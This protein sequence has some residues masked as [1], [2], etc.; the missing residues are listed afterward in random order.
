M[1][2]MLDASRGAF[3]LSFA[4]CN[5]PALRDHVIVRLQESRS[6]IE[7]VRVPRST[8]D[9]YGA[10]VAAAQDDQRTALFVVGLEDS[11]DSTAADHPTLRSL[12]FSRDLWES[13]FHCPVVFWLPEFAI[14]LLSQIARDFYRYRSHRFEFI[15][16][17]ATPIAGMSDRFAGDLS[18]ASNLSA[19]EKRFRIAELEQRIAEAGDPPPD[20]L[21]LYVLAWMTELGYLH[22]SLSEH[23]Q[24][25]AMHKKLLAIFE[26]HGWLEGMAS[27]FGNLGNVYYA[28]QEL[29]RAE[30]MHARAL[31]I[32]EKLGRLEGMANA[33]GHLGNVYSTRGELDQGE[34]FYKKALAIEEELGRMEGIANAYGNLGVIYKTRGELD[35]AEEMYRK[36]LAVDEKLGRLEGMADDYG[37]LGNVYSMRGEL[38]R[39]EETYR[40][41]LAIDEKIGRLEGVANAHGSL[42]ILYE[43]KGDLTR[44]REHGTKAWRTYAKAQM[45]HKAKQMQDWLDDLD[46][47]PQ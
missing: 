4:L 47:K 10:V 30:E 8:V 35:R 3:S 18:A 21:M 12:N 24:A 36:A 43:T 44:A 28:R 11:L 5:S 40:K 29:D 26:K 46:A 7:A 34:A 16:E 17:Q 27:A 37:N 32:N 33:Y 9:V 1:R 14:K 41:A 19:D 22:Y 31:A 6:G 23:D 45:P 25:E 42:G 20:N 38:D 15:S 13:R 2:R 39:A